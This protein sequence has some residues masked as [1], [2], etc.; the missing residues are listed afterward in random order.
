M[1]ESIEIQFLGSDRHWRR[2]QG[3]VQN[4]DQSIARALTVVKRMHPESRVRAVGQQ[5]GRVY[6]MIT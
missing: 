5:S 2:I 6:D 4:R 1:N 3:G